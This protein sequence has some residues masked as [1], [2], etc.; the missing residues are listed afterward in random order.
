MAVTLDIADTN[1]IHPA[2]KKDVGERLAF[3]ALAKLYGR[4]LVY[5]G[6]L[7]KSMKVIKNKIELEFENIGSGLE[8]RNGKNQFQIAGADQQFVK[9]ETEIKNN[10]I[11]IW[12]KGVNYPLAVRYAW[13]NNA[14]AI[15][16]NKEGL[17]ASSFRTDNWNN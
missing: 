4:N 16:F 14:N 11:I 8:I 3:W 10:K 7:Y 12:N 6:P 13:D 1:N 5:S 15:L 17:P 2:N 9:A